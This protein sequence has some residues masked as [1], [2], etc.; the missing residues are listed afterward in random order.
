MSA[1]GTISYWLAPLQIIKKD[2][3]HPLT[4]Q[5]LKEKDIV[6]IQRGATGFSAANQELMAERHRATLAI[7]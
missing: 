2:W 4:G 5:S 7:S 6:Y 3:Q 1:L